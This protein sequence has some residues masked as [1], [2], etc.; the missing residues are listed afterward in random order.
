MALPTGTVTFLLTDIEGSTR[1]LQDLRDRYPDV[2]E[3]F[4]QSRTEC[5]RLTSWPGLE[6]TGMDPPIQGVQVH[7]E[8]SRKAK[9]EIP[10]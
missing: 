2:L 6:E 10:A 1:L 4:R 3:V 5:G 9:T 7:T 8:V